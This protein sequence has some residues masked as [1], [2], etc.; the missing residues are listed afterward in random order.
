MK[1]KIEKKQIEKELKSKHIK[2][3]I[4]KEV[5]KTLALIEVA[6][7]TLD[8]TNRES[9][10]VTPS[11]NYGYTSGRCVGCTTAA[12]ATTTTT[13][14]ANSISQTQQQTKNVMSFIEIV[15][16]GVLFPTR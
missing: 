11:L 10:A 8:C 16:L 3:Q 14:T 7:K 2:K 9:A 13:A 12:A 15:G 6:P 4:R 1:N 5:K